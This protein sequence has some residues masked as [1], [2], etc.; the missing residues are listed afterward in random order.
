MSFFSFSLYGEL[1]DLISDIKPTL[2]YQNHA[3]LV[4]ISALIFIFFL[5][6]IHSNL[7]CM[8]PGFLNK[9]WGY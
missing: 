2:L 8:S 4:M 7:I 6:T 9:N 3:Y 1:H 5:S